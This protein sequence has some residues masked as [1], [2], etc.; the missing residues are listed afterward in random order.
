MTKK[1]SKKP[2]SE[3]RVK[4]PDAPPNV[5]RDIVTVLRAFSNHMHEQL[6]FPPHKG[7]KDKEERLI[8]LNC[9]RA[10]LESVLEQRRG[11]KE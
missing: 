2:K 6:N 1:H 5:A 3:R 7:D 4:L 9:W 10:Q 11:E 8:A